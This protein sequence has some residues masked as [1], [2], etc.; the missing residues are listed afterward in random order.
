MRDGRLVAR[1]G[2]GWGKVVGGGRGRRGRFFASLVLVLLV[3]VNSLV[4]FQV[5]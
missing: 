3:T 2:C 5:A 4:S 1:M